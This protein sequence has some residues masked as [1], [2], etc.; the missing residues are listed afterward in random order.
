MP[1]WRHLPVTMLLLI[2][3][4][5]NGYSDWPQFRGPTADGVWKTDA[6]P[7]SW[8]ESGPERVWEAKVGDGYGGISV[9]QGRVYLMD[10]PKPTVKG[11]NPDGSE[12]VLCFHADTGELLWNVEYPAHYGD[13]DYGNGPRSTPTIVDGLV[14][15]LGAV[16]HVCCLRADTGE[17][18]WE[19]EMVAEEDAQIPMWGF[20]ASPLVV[21][22]LVILHTGAR[23]NGCFIAYNRLTGKEVWRNLEDPAGYCTPTVVESPSGP[24]LLAWTPENIHGLNPRTGER[25]WTVPY[26]VTYGVSIASPVYHHGIVVVTGYWEGTKAI[27]LGDTPTDAELVWEENEFLR[28]LMSVPLC[29]D[30]YVY[31]ID[32]RFGLTCFEVA[33]GRKLW[34]ADN[35]LTPRGRNPQATFVWLG[36]SKRV[37]AFNAQGELILARFTPEGYEEESRAK[38]VEP[39]PVTWAYPAYSNGRAYVHNGRELVCVKLKD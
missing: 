22:E 5:I 36:D 32:K 23:P 19:K 21:D 26:K 34:D 9:A 20:A 12:R 16:G 25:Y 31:S 35:I 13:L 3:A 27:R 15:T 33:T 4:P 8:P 1:L 39:N 17:V 30:G 28:G 10:R 11:Q 37:V 29:K 6:L 7:E 14:Y 24:Q 2:L 18:V 38:V